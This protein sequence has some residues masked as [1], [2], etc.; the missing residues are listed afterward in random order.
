MFVTSEVN[1]LKVEFFKM[2]GRKNKSE[3]RLFAV[4]EL[5][6]G[7]VKRDSSQGGYTEK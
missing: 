5:K 1:S 4:E 2:F 3:A 7:G 6:A